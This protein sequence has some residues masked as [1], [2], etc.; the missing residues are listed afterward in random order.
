MRDSGHQLELIPLG[1]RPRN[2]LDLGDA[3]ALTH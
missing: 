1:E 3:V 2:L